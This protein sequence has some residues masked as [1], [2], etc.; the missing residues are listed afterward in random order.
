MLFQFLDS[1]LDPSSSFNVQNCI[2]FQ[3]F[4]PI[5]SQT[6]FSNFPIDL[7]REFAAKVARFE[8]LKVVLE[9]S[10]LKVADKH[11]LQL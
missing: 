1:V 10:Q 6:H 11:C 7:C 4:N 3:K 8:K 2:I 5:V 9:A